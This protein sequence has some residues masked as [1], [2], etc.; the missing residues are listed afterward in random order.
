MKIRSAE[1]LI[2]NTDHRKCPE[3]KF[4][5][6]A[7]IGRS[8][9]GKSSLINMLCERKKLAKTS[10]TP[11]KT[12][13]I[14]H[15]LINEHIYLVDLPGYGFAKVS[16]KEREKWEKMI[17]TYLN[18]RPNLLYTFVLLDSRLPAQKIDLE[19]MAKLGKKGLPF[20]MLFTKIDK[21]SSSTLNKNLADYK[22]TML[23][24]WAE[25][26][27]IITTSSESKIGKEDVWNLIEQTN[28]DYSI[29]LH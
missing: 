12:Q 26:P 2:S 3:A 15:F 28:R 17:H 1:F 13:L 16:K 9:V 8:N 6:Y 19:F 5:E 25:L 29:S 23:K 21:L 4:P 24:E 10:T 20:V 27:P 18:Q 7:F 11:G 14:N 22:K